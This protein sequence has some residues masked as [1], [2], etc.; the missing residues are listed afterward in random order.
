M[1][2]RG[3]LVESKCGGGGYICIGWIEFFSYYEMFCDLFY[4]IGEWVS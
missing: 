3:Y 2:S 4:L 1:E